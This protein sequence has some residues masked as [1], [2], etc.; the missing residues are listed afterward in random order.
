MGLYDKYIL[1]F[2]TDLV[3]GGKPIAKQRQKIVPQA[4]GTVLEVGIGSGLNLPFYSSANIEKVW[5]LEPSAEMRKMAEKTAAKVD[6][7][8]EFLDLPGEEIPL[9]DK[10]VDTVL[11]TYALC[12][13]PDTVKALKQMRRVLKPGA[14]L[15]F[16]EHGR[17]PD[18][19]VQRWQ[20]RIDPLW[21][22]F[23]GGCHLNRPI[24]EMVKN[25]GFR[26]EKLET[27]Y[28]PG[29]RTHSYNYWGTAEADQ[30]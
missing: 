12:T 13:I 5:G 22:R 3:C 20:N 19:S 21:T 11:I 27:M 15:L 25:A 14:K 29:P 23:A 10:S 17:A 6:F 18:E 30:N 28:I 2:A 8:V 7:P 4:R 1:P 9:D 26:I 24:D 16:C